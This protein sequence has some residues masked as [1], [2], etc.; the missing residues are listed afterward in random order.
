MQVVV[1]RLVVSLCQLFYVQNLM[2]LFYYPGNYA[3]S[4]DR[5]S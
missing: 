1:I 5:P 2:A 3:N 4:H